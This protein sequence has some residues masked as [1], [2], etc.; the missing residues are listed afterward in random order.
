V[1]ELTSCPF[2]EGREERTPPETLAL[3]RANGAPDTPGW[4]VRVVPNLYPAL[5][6]QEVVINTPRHARSVSELAE[7]ELRA[8]AVAWSE[9][10]RAA[11]VE[12]FPYLQALINEGRDAGA[13]LA[14][15]HS[16]LAWLRERPPAVAAE[17]RP[18]T[19]PCPV[20]AFLAAEIND[21]RRIIA[22]KADVVVLAAFAGRLPYELLIAPLRHPT[23]AAFASRLLGE[24]LVLLGDAVRRLHALEGPVPLNAW[25]HDGNHWHLEVVPRLSVLAGLEL[26]AGLYVNT[27]APEEAAERLR[28]E[29]AG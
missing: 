23:G 29:R 11:E 28:S 2:C 5:E 7:D 27:L 19:D 18:T 10:A 15:S 21:G 25:L 17:E 6:R 24:A 8:V 16:Q 26:G 9:R 3:G 22:R 20:C 14:H 1:E 12:G 4:R 13:S